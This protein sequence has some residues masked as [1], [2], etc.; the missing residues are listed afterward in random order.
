MRTHK[1]NAQPTRYQVALRAVGAALVV[2]ATEGAPRAVDYKG[3]PKALQTA[4]GRHFGWLQALK[5]IEAE[6]EAEIAAGN[7]S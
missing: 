3:R 2:I 5:A 6:L 1:K 7:G 4:R